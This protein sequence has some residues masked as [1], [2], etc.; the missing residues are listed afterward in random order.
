MDI[1]DRGSYRNEVIDR[2]LETEKHWRISNTRLILRVPWHPKWSLCLRL[3]HIKNVQSIPPESRRVR[4]QKE[5]LKA[6]PINITTKNRSSRVGGKG[7]F[8]LSLM[9]SE[10][11]CG[12]PAQRHTRASLAS[13][14]RSTGCLPRKHY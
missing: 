7:D 6:L 13:K 11:G 4:S 1:Q 10:I 3:T 2:Y 12:T 9:M 14:H 5:E 8:R